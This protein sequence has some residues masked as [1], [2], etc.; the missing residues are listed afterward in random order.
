M[1]LRGPATANGSVRVDGAEWKEVGS[2]RGRGTVKGR[3]GEVAEWAEFFLLVDVSWRHTWI[4]S[5]YSMDL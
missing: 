1:G 3:G 5:V 2:D 4:L